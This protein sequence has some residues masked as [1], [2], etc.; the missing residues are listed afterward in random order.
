LQR[1]SCEKAELTVWIM[2][3]RNTASWKGSPGVSTANLRRK[4]AQ[5][6][7]FAKGLDLNISRMAI[8]S[9][10]HSSNLPLLQ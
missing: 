7:Q 10:P 1:Q 5:L 6:K 4:H 3:P 9:R 8:L 2:M